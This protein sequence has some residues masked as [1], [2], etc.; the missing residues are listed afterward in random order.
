MDLRKAKK[1]EIVGHL[2]DEKVKRIVLTGAAGVGKTWIANEIRHSC[3]DGSPGLSYTPIWVPLNQR[4]DYSNRKLLRRYLHEIIAREL[5]R[6]STAEELDDTASKEDEPKEESLGLDSLIKDRISAAAKLEPKKYDENKPLLLILDGVPDTLDEADIMAELEALRKP[7]VANMGTALFNKVLITRRSKEVLTKEVGETKEMIVT[8]PPLP[9]AVDEK[10]AK[11]ITP[12]DQTAG[13]NDTKPPPDQ[14]PNQMINRL[15]DEERKVIEIKA[16][17]EK[18]GLTLF[19]HIV[20]HEKVKQITDFQKHAGDIIKK[21]KGFPAAIIVIAEALKYIAERDS[22]INL[23]ILEDAL[24]KAATGEE[25]PDGSWHS[26]R[27]FQKP[28]RVHYNELI[29]CWILEANVG[30]V[31]AVYGVEEAYNVGHCVL[32]KLI[33]RQML[34]IQDDNTVA[35]EELAFTVPDCREGAPPASTDLCDGIIMCSRKKTIGTKG[36]HR[37]CDGLMCLSN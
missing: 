29:A 26:P 36:R 17:S 23:T 28:G 14:K 32:M 16:L 24:K 19:N 4:G 11:N 7:L 3:T 20:T 12:A 15:S 22:E 21:S 30:A 34:K 6:N 31:T 1:D 18:E 13:A 25:K 9:V 8:K 5:P 27:F 35:M 37:V 2:K 33:D 10:A